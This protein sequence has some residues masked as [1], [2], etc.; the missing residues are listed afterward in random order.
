[1]AERRIHVPARL[2]ETQGQDHRE[3]FRV[4]W[5]SHINV[6]GMS[7]RAYP[8]RSVYLLAFFCLC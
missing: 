7:R 3:R 8:L 1:M 4:D 5:P 6:L 2:H